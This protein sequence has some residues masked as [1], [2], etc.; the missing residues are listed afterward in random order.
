[1]TATIIPFPT[2]RTAASAQL[3][4]R[5]SYPRWM[6]LRDGGVRH[7]IIYVW[8]ERGEVTFEAMCG[9]TGRSR[10]GTDA[11]CGHCRRRGWS[12]DA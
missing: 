9:K 6:S 7:R 11:V 12:P 5:T 3:I 4:D 8:T 1:M 2:R 10:V